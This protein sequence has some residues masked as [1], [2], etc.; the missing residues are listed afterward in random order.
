M[1][2]TLGVFAMSVINSIVTMM[3]AIHPSVFAMSV[4]HPIVSVMNVIHCDEYHSS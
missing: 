3:N 2:F 1:S 4:I